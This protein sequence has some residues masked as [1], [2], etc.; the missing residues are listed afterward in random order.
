M[1]SRQAEKERRKRERLEHERQVEAKARRRR[2]LRVL[3][4]VAGGV[5]AFGAIAGAAVLGSGGEPQD[6]ASEQ[7]FGQHYKGLEERRQK[8]GVPTMMDT[9]GQTIHIHPRMAVYIDGRPV[10]IPA[11]IG[12]HPEKPGMDMA[13][14][15]THDP[16]GTLHVEG[17]ADATLGQ[18]FEVWGV[19]F[20]EAQLG[21]YHAG[22]GKVMRMWVD[23]K[24]SKEFGDLQL[25]DN[26]NIVVAFGEKRAAPPPGV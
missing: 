15:H 3:G 13:A 26:Q 21:P 24:P 14:L 6:T 2:R 4:A 9:M 25:R 17:M 5:L 23:G 12:I 10:T 16:Q 20:S 11:D 8:A 7:L 19:P 22:G 1:S 18:F